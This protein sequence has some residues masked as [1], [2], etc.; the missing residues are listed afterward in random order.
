MSAPGQ[1]LDL[2]PEIGASI[3]RFIYLTIDV[4]VHKAQEDDHTNGSS[5]FVL[6][7]TCPRSWACTCYIVTSWRPPVAGQQAAPLAEITH[8]ASNN[9]PRSRHILSSEVQ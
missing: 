3:Y 1:R 8:Q 7:V 5:K 2:P 6:G 4:D 9:V